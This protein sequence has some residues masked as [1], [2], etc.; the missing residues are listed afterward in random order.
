VTTAQLEALRA[1]VSEGD[2]KAAAHSLGI[3]YDRLRHRL[4]AVHRALG[5]ETT[6]Q[7]VY[8]LTVRGELVVPGRE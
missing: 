1:L 6:V 7:A 8:V 5:V 4:A 3:S 2:G